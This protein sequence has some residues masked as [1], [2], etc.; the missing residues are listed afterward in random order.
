MR[1]KILL[2][3]LIF[4]CVLIDI[5]AQ[6]PQTINFLQKMFYTGQYSTQHPQE[7]NAAYICNVFRSVKKNDISIISP[8]SNRIDI[9]VMFWIERENNGTI[10]LYIIDTEN[11]NVISTGTLVVKEHKYENGFDYYML[12]CLYD[13]LMGHT[14]FTHQLSIY[15]T[16]AANNNMFSIIM[17]IE[18]TLTLNLAGQAG[19]GLNGYQNSLY[20]ILK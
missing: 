15:S 5:N 20:D 18:E 13:N 6:P 3:V 17:P 9:S 8:E 11:M 14:N 2:L 10:M 12:D 19:V 7:E 16:R 4:I 1:K